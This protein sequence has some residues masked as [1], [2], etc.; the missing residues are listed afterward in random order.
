M[1]IR[2]I[3]ADDHDLVRSCIRASLSSEDVE[4]VSEVRDGRALLTE[5]RRHRPDV[6]VVD[7]SMPLLN[8][9]EAT[10]RVRR[11][12]PQTQVVILTMHAD[13]E[14][15]RRARAAGAFEYVVK[16]ESPE[17]LAQAIADAAAA[18]PPTSESSADEEGP[19]SPREQEVLQLI[20]EGKRNRE[21]AEVMSR[22]VHTV[23][24]HRAR[25]MAK[26][27]AHTATEL[28]KFAEDRRLLQWPR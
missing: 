4:V 5:V 20:A 12:S 2:V 27:G 11:V 28:L 24:A 23:R 19:L 8:G 13:E 22:S 1:T 15:V 26:L 10:K 6:A 25:L 3:L 16:D 14:L 7:I 21:I 18:T 9:I 17:R